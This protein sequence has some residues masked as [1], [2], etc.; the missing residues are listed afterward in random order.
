VLLCRATTEKH[1]TTFRKDALLDE[2][3]IDET[4]QNKQM[5]LTNAIY[6][7]GVDRFVFFV[8]TDANIDY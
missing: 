8:F 2:L 7:S 6:L 4:K 3:I 1:R 5:T